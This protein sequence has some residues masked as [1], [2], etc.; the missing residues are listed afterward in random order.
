MKLKKINLKIG[1]MSC[2]SCVQTIEKALKSREGVFSAAVNFA[3]EKAVIEYYPDKIKKNGL[4]KVI[5]NSGYTVLKEKT[6]GIDEEKMMRA[7]KKRMFWAWIFT[8]PII[9]WM[10]PGMV[11]GVAWPNQLTY[12]LGLII[13]ATAVLFG[14]GLKT[15]RSAYQAIKNFSANMDVLIAMG[16]LAS[17]L[18]GIASLFSPVANFAGVAAMIMA[19]HLTGR[20]IETKA[21]GRAS[22]AIR[23]LLELGAKT[24]RIL[25]DGRQREIPVA[26]IK[27]GNIMLVK[28]G[29]KIPTDGKV[30]EGKSFVDESMATGESMPVGKKAGQDVIGATINKEGFLKVQAN[31][32]GKDTFLSQMIKMVQECQ[33]SKVPI[34]EFADKITSFFVPVIL[35]I[36]LL[37]FFSW[38]MFPQF[39][40][41]ILVW[42]QSFI[43]WVIPELGTV[44]LAVFAAVAV[45]VIACPCALGLATP[46]A[47]M[48]GSGK[49]AEEGILIREGAAI[50]TL[51]EIDT[52]VFDK[53]GT[54]TKGKPEV[55]EIKTKNK[56]NQE[57]VL[58]F[59]ASLE[60]L[61]E[62]PLAS[63]IITKAKAKNIKLT[64]VT[65]FKAISGKGVE[66]TL[67]GKNVLVGSRKIVTDIKIDS[68][69]EKELTAIESQ[70][71]TAIL[72][73]Y[74]QEIAGIIAVAD[75]L[76]ED[77]KQAISELNK[78]GIKT[79]MLTGDNKKTAEAIAK[80]LNI[81]RVL[82]EVLPD[83]KVAEVKKLQKEVGKVAMVGDGINDAPALT[84]ADVGIAIGTGTDIAIEASDVTLVSGQLSAVV[85]AVKLSKATFSK[86]KQNLFW[87]FGYNIVAIP[88]AVL[89][90]LHPVVA[91][92]AMAGSSITVVT[93]ANRLK[94]V[95]IN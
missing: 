34:Q 1:G 28:P 81:S 13:L 17:Y 23:K 15:L 59:A 18:C 85:K 30:I 20:F 27:V 38:I 2:A 4:I 50:Q 61:S 75:T 44:S 87:A 32:V 6:A 33:S 49:G 74:G 46:T 25:V 16:T 47:L 64:S 77:S 58:K 29:E 19:F 94:K 83:Q 95:N 55:T 51:R 82:A 68:I 12:D 26:E 90:L 31:K 60:S 88:I 57:E 72:V 52:I 39:F 41:N 14:M 24:A 21:K 63:A 76:K 93:N 22:L 5:E 9:A 36:A 73:F 89:G 40:A 42:A 53:T 79:T 48:V 54:I 56:F 84:Q 7:A 43:P 67:E 92:I 37:T 11:L 71:K 62:H 8:G 3:T 65:N 45:L 69:T 10:I 80:Q 66:A 91:E 86:I 70:G 35:A 78:L